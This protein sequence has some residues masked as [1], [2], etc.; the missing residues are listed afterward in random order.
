MQRV[1]IRTAIAADHKPLEALQWRASLS[2]P[3]EREALLAHP[4]AIELP[5]QHIESCHVF[6]AEGGGAI[7][8]YATM[9]PRQDGHCELDALFVQPLDWRQ[10][11]GRHLVEYCCSQA[12]A[13]GATELRVVGNPHAQGF[14]EATGFVALGTQK[15]RFGVGLLMKRSV[16]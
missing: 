4:E 8:G 2:N 11:V 5:L 7:K 15:M 10:G 3:A 13:A 9:V 6:V 12:K 1:T 14:Y 16:L